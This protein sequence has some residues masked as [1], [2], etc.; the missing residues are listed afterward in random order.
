[1]KALQKDVLQTALEIQ[2]ELLGSTINFSPQR[3]RDSTRVDGIGLDYTADMRDSFHVSNGLSNSSWFFHSPLQYW[4]CDLEKI[5]EDT[6]IITTINQHSNQ[7]TSVNVTLRHPLVFSAKRF[8]EHR[9]VAADALAITLIHGLDSPVGKQWEIKAREMARRRSAKWNV[10]PEEVLSLSSELYQFQFQGLSWFDWTYFAI[11][12]AWAVW[13]YWRGISKIRA[14]KSRATLLFAIVAHIAASVGS[15]FTFCAILRIDLSKL[16]REAYPL[17]AM[18]ISLENIFRLTRAIVTTP[19]NRTIPHRVGEALGQVGHL[20]LGSALG[21]LVFLG[22]IYQ[23]SHSGIRAFCKFAAFAVCFEVVY[24]VLFFTAVLS[25]DIKKTELE[26]SLNSRRPAKSSSDLQP[27]KKTWAAALLSGEASVF[28]RIAGTIVILFFVILAYSHFNQDGMTSFSRVFDLLRPDPGP[29][30]AK[31]LRKAYVDMHPARDPIEWLRLQDHETSK[32][33]IRVIKPHAS[34]ALIKVYP[35]LAFVLEGSDREPND[36]GPRQFLPAFYDLKNH[37][38]IAYCLVVAASVVLVRLLMNLYL[39]GQLPNKDDDEHEHIPLLTVKTLSEGH[40]LDIMLLTASSDGALATVGLDRWIRIWD[41]RNDVTGYIVRDK[42]ADVDV[43]PFPVL[44]I[45][46]DRNSN[47]LALLSAKD[48][49]YLWNIPEKRWGPSKQVELRKR[50]PLAFFFGKATGELI[51]P[52]F[53]VRHSGLMSELHME[54]QVNSDLQICRGPLVSVQHHF[55]NPTASSSNPPPRIITSSKKGCVHVASHLEQGWVSDGLEVPYP[56]DDP[57]ILSILPLPAL[58]SFLAVRKHTVDLI[59]IF[60]RKVTHT[61]ITK[62]MKPGSLRCFHSARRRPQCGSVSLATLALAYTC[63]ETGNCIMQSYLPER[64]GD[65]IC[66][67]DPYTPGSKTCCLWRETVENRHEMENPGQWETLQVGYVVGIRKRES[68]AEPIQPTGR[69]D[70]VVANSGLRR[71]GINERASQSSHGH[72]EDDAWEAWSMSNRGEKSTF[73]LFDYYD[74]HHLLVSSTG[75]M[76]KVG[77]RSI[78]FA[79][80]NVVKV[81][82]VGIDKF[83]DERSNDDGV[84][85]GMAAASSRRKRPSAARVRAMT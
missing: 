23:V 81:V 16:P 37:G 72:K 52:I 44:A 9:L 49:V 20:A 10:V 39:R 18:F 41:I 1:M 29:S 74:K 35:P 47:W 85:V 7:S 33:V 70:Q 61:F 63:A 58:S 66:F 14:L 80:G 12:Y 65:T 48:R 57:D 73:P 26:D 77:H 11:G 54:S 6:N 83:D 19:P 30:K 2:D 76:V 45:A 15:S 42:T 84:Y 27:Q 78:A 24:L 34:S 22:V 8:E 4:S 17:V 40:T 43:N 71:R 46:I 79:I 21:Y 59:D 62:P 28:R 38:K 75:P 82:S 32:E 3:T 69:L 36:D 25:V 53:I 51:D 50:K 55:E 31:S 68:T 64:E 56:D 13:S 60:T 5:K 67:R